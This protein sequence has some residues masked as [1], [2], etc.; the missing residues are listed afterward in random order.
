[1]LAW[2]YTIA[3]R[4]FA[5]EARRRRHSMNGLP[6]DDFLEEAP[7]VEYGPDVARALRDGI[8]RLSPEQRQVVCMKLLC[9]SSFGDIATAMDVS[10]AAAKMRFQR[11]LS[12]L[13]ANFEE[14][15]IGP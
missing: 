4:R 7:A 10:E 6:L 2:L 8:S 14:Q 9:G 12:A 13:R 3:Q 5:D 1:M 15:G 11:A